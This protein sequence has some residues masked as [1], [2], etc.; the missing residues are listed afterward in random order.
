MGATELRTLYAQTD[1]PR[2][3]AAGELVRRTLYERMLPGG[4]ASRIIAYTEQGHDEKLLVVHQREHRSG[5]MTQ[6]DPK[7][8]WVGGVFYWTK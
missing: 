6:P 4:G 3:I 8:V 7:L 5:A 2:R 1:Y